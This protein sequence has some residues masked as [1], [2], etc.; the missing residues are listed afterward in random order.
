[1]WYLHAFCGQF[2]QFGLA[3]FPALFLS[4]EVKESIFEVEAQMVVTVLL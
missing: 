1:M 2:L 3:D 4:R